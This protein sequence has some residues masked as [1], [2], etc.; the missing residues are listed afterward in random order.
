MTSIILFVKRKKKKQLTNKNSFDN[1][2][3]LQSTNLSLNFRGE[4]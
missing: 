3:S 4:M 2:R 1:Y